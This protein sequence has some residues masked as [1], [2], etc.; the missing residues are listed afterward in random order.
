MGR[1]ER[2]N[3]WQ[4]AEAS[5]NATPHGIQRLLGRANWDADAVRDDLRAYVVEH[6]G[7]TDGVLIVD[8]TGFLK[9]G[10]KSVGV[11]RQYSGMAGRVLL[12]YRSSRG[13]AFLDRT[14]YMPKSWTNDASRRREAGVPEDVTFATKPELARVML[15]RARK[16]GVPARW[17]TAD[18]VY[19]SDSQFRRRLEESG[20]SYVVAVTSAQRLFLGGLY[21]RVDELTADLTTG[22]WL[23]LSCGAGSKGQRL[24]DWAFVEFPHQRSIL[25]LERAT[26]R[27]AGVLVDYRKAF[28]FTA[29]LKLAPLTMVPVKFAP[30]KNE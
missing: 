29:P 21:G 5:G 30:I 3:S 26:R 8:E 22:A 9:K 27:G 14:L 15:R 13:A 1:V 16:A 11:Q 6:L 17:A 20:L 23:R 7:E 24:Y 19:G 18:E 10:D 28:Y 25:F 2:K 12:A 4:L